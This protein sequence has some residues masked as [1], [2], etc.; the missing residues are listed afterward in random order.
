MNAHVLH[1]SLQ[2]QYQQLRKCSSVSSP[3]SSLDQPP[4]SPP[5]PSPST[6]HQRSPSSHC[7]H[8][9]PSSH[10]VTPHGFT[11]TSTSSLNYLLSYLTNALRRSS[12]DRRSPSP[13][14][15]RASS[16]TSLST[17]PRALSPA[18]Q[19][20]AVSPSTVLTHHANGGGKIP[21]GFDL[22]ELIACTPH[23]T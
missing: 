2:K 12:L 17:C 1:V 4:S 6:S 21:A 14:I 20:C 10:M 13:V 15:P 8:S 5:S 7:T 11:S 3:H 19:Q 23:S 18:R 22:L 9:L 16:P